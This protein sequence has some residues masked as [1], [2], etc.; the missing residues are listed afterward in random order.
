METIIFASVMIAIA[1]GIIYYYNRNQ[2][3]LDINDD[4]LVDHKDVSQAVQNTANGLVRDTRDA[5]DL[6]L[7]L[8]SE[9]A[10]KALNAVEKVTKP[11][12]TSA[13]KPATKKTTK[14]AAGTVKKSRT[15][16]K[17]S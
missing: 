16:K 13:P 9:S 11:K 17:S 8:A 10:A 1:G 12:R 2:K 3:T 4:G 7:N 5:R 6:A 15:T 14:P